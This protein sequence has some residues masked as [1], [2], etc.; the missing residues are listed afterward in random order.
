MAKRKSDKNETELGKYKKE[1]KVLK[2]PFAQIQMSPSSWIDDRLP[3]VIWMALIISQLSREDALDFFRYCLKYLQGNESLSDLTHSGIGRLSEQECTDL[4][5]HFTAYDKHNVIDLLRPILVLS[6]LPAKPCWGKAL[7]KISNEED[8]WVKLANAVRI[9]FSH[10]SQEATDCRWV[11]VAASIISGKMKMR[12]MV[13]EILLYPNEGDQRQVRPTIRAAEI[14]QK[15]NSVTSSWPNDFWKEC[16][17]RTGCHPE[18]A[19]RKAIK[20]KHDELAATLEESRKYYFDQTTEIR[21]AII[22]HFFNTVET[23]AVDPRHEAVFGITL[24][25]F[26]VFIE[27]I[28]YR[29]SVAVNGRIMLRV[30]FEAYATLSYL[31]AKEKSDPAIWQGYR[32]YG[33]GQANLIYRKYEE[34]GFTSSSVNNEDIEM[35]ANEDKWVEF[36]PINV[37]HWDA[38]DLRK[39]CDSLGEKDLYDKYYAYTSSFIHGSWLAVRETEFQKCLNPLHRLHRIPGYGLPLMS[40]VT[41]DMVELTNKLLE[42]LSKAYPTFNYRIT[43]RERPVAPDKQPG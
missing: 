9:V 27:N 8:S 23:S 37:G 32:S 35:I 34:A 1:G 26:G 42:L 13:K 14:A 20:E 17:D 21:K 33:S 12:S 19:L 16:F 2:P 40:S 36:V 39:I 28:F 11:K 38:T 15:F 22:D 5:A 10:Q 29:A 43:N 24:Y 4:L 7:G 30:L 3:E 41:P 31:L 25:G 18:Q 6:D